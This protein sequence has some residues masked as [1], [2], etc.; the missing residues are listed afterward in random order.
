MPEDKETLH[1]MLQAENE[2]A[3]PERVGQSLIEFIQKI[4]YNSGKSLHQIYSRYQIMDKRG[5]SLM[6]RE[7][8]LTLMR[9][10]MKDLI[11]E[12]EIMLSYLMIPKAEESAVT[13]QEFS[14]VFSVNNPAHNV[15]FA[16]FPGAVKAEEESEVLKKVHEWMYKRQYDPA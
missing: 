9:E 11:S 3:E 10:M 13:W 7:A 2:G 6:L 1:K 8:Y 15:Q 14:K 12:E 4:F 16:V 5:K